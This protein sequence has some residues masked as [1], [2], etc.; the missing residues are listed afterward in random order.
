MSISCIGTKPRRSKCPY[1]ESKEDYNKTTKYPVCTCGY[2][3]C[4][5]YYGYCPLKRKD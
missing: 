3:Y 2:S 4:K 5:N 1:L